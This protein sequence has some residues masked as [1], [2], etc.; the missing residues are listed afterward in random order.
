MTAFAFPRPWHTS[1]YDG[2]VYLV[3]ANGLTVTEITPGQS[4]GAVPNTIVRRALAEYVR[5]AVNSPNEQTR[6]AEGS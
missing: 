3:A 6:Q 4:K 1:E 5:S 2:R